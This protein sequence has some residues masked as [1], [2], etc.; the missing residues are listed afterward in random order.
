MP[1]AGQG[2]VAPDGRLSD[3]IAVGLLVR[4]FP[5]HLVDRVIA[6]CGRTEQR[7]R[8]LPA[9]LVVYFV[10][11]MCL[12]SA[13][14]YCEVAQLLAHGMTWAGHANGPLWVPT[15]AAISRA[16]AKL[17][18]EPLAALFAAVAG[19]PSALV[20]VPQ[21]PR[22]RDD[23]ARWRALGLDST[24][25]SVPDSA[26]NRE[27][28]G[29]PVGNCPAQHAFPEVRVAAL[30]DWASGTIARAVFGSRTLTDAA[31][32]DGL[33]TDLTR[34]DL[35]LVDDCFT[36]RWPTTC[37]MGRN[38]MWRAH[39]RAQL[40]VRRT[41]TDGSYLT[42]ITVA[43]R[44]A[45][46]AAGRFAA[47]VITASALGGAQSCRLLTTVLDHTTSPARALAALYHERG[48]LGRCLQDM[49]AHLT[50]E[51]RIV[52]RSRWPEGVEQEL[53]GHL[54]IHH[55]VRMSLHSAASD[56]PSLRAT[57]SP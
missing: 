18:A 54:L 43:D 33:I 23:R 47:R 40:P 39:P 38:L 22:R 6:D 51:P 46:R 48:M 30:T 36:D 9:R 19:S 32:V 16:R 44:D 3:R 7:S 49:R 10:L 1:R 34:G 17:G 50:S 25:F 5:P 12:F 42:E 27:R 56:I 21:Q 31:L 11:A 4:A 24:V 8:V 20:S 55:A 29:A 35:L 37:A 41:L 13:E 57:G 53:W 45:G 2:K 15:T 52:L 28:F 14:S 26:E